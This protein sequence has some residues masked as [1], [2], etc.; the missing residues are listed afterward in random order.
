[1]KL[2]ASGATHPGRVRGRNEDAYHV[3]PGLYVVADGM[4]GSH[5]GD[6]AAETA[7]SVVADAWECGLDVVRSNGLDLAA[8]LRLCAEV[9]NGAIIARAAGSNMGTTVVCLA[10]EGARG[11]VAWVGD[12][13]CGR[14]RGGH[15]EWL[16]R[17]HSLRATVARS[18]KKPLT[19][20]ELAQV[21]A[22]ILTRALGRAGTKVDVE[23]VDVRAGDIFLLCSDGVWGELEDSRIRELDIGPLFG[24]PSR[25]VHPVAPASPEEVARNFMSLALEFGGR[26]NCTTVVVRVEA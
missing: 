6:V 21:P 20:V 25:A 10:V 7:C 13:R 17:D 3:G 8:R 1:V 18:H 24:L 22:N 23:E 12:S 15:F 5:R 9:A 19:D 16:T 4:G 2:S 11:A 26:D 14:L